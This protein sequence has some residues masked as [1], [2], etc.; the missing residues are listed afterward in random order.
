M[1]LVITRYDDLENN[2]VVFDSSKFDLYYDDDPFPTDT[3]TDFDN[4]LLEQGG[5]F[6]VITQTTTTDGMGAVTN[7]SETSFNIHAWVTDIN[8][9]ERMIHEM[10]LAVPGN[11]VIYLKPNYP[12]VSGGVTNDYIVKE[13]DVFIDRNGY[14][15]RF[16][17]I[18]EEPYINAT[19][20]YQKCVIKNIG[21]KGSP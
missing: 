20:I 11:R 10:G 12:I 16:V 3:A 6:Q 9:K 5:I 1:A 14:R 19:P 4:I 15:L 7:V 2:N 21:L 13:G 8:K 18:I 17:K